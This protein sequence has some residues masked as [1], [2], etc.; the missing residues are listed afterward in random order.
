MWTLAGNL[1][2]SGCQWG[3]LVAIAKLGTVEGVGYFGLAFAITAPIIIFANM[4]LCVVAGTDTKRDYLFSDYL[5]LRIITTIIALP[6]MIGFGVISGSD[7]ESVLII[8]V[9]GV[10]KAIESM[11]DIVYG[12]CYQQERLER[13][14][15]SM[16]L[17]GLISLATLCTV[18]YV[19]RS[20]LYASISLAISWAIIVVLYD[21]K[22]PAVIARMA[23][24]SH[25]AMV[26]DLNMHPHFNW[27]KLR[28]LLT[29]ALPLGFVTML[30]SLT[31]N[32]PRY[33]IEWCFGKHDLGIFVALA[34]LMAAGNTIFTALGQSTMPRMSKYY[35]AKDFRAFKK[36]L[37]KQVA[38]A[39]ML[40]VCGVLL[41]SMAGQWLL[42]VIY[43]PEYATHQTEFIW[44][45]L[46]TGIGFIGG[47]LGQGVT[48]ARA[49]R[50]LT[51][52]SVTITA[53]AIL[54]SWML[55]PKFGILG[56]AWTTGL[57][58]VVSCIM[59]IIILITLL[60][61]EAC[62]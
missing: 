47:Y 33:F 23:R 60:R 14:A 35:A 56:A 43:K 57:V 61:K 20:I 4:Q 46:G 62:S 26:E 50:H 41:V 51:I 9:I 15:I 29:L 32:G 53:S 22:S 8:I 36:L 39:A 31:L 25:I 48:A 54:I 16:I 7:R 34:Y 10:A 40:T 17:K 21:I 59:P 19:T 37:V 13:V 52:S 45:T 55:I 5:G 18:M 44:L 42:S 38:F 12:P 28:K 24:E 27:P 6:A 58:G 30:G 2:Y 11:S 1:T 49:Y 3:M